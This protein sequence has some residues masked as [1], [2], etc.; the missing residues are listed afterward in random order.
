MKQWAS[1]YW[2][3]IVA[4]LCFCAVFAACSSA[5]ASEHAPSFPQN[6][7]Q[8]QAASKPSS[9]SI[10]TIPYLKGYALGEFGL[11]FSIPTDAGNTISPSHQKSLSQTGKAA[12]GPDYHFWQGS[13]S[14]LN[15]SGK[16]LRI[17][18][19]MKN[20]LPNAPDVDGINVL[21]SLAFRS[22]D[23]TPECKA[24][25]NGAILDY[26]ALQSRVFYKTE[27][28]VL[29]DFTDYSFAQDGA[30]VSI[31]DEMK[32]RWPEGHPDR[33]WALEVR[34]YYLKNIEKALVPAQ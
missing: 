33:A 7:A 21:V 9:A 6:A 32:A 23:F 10:R 29:C 11:A 14:L 13:S 4:P 26:E 17:S 31:E 1:F 30:A 27:Q 34:E 28:F 15:N 2:Q 24:W 18:A 19:T 12:E 8:S 5:V 3:S 25:L 20:L 16:E 22:E